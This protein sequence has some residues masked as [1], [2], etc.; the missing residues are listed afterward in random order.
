[1]QWIAELIINKSK[2][3]DYDVF[4]LVS[5]I[6]VIY[7]LFKIQLILSLT[8]DLTSCI[9]LKWQLTTKSYLD[10]Y[11]TFLSIAVLF[12]AWFLLHCKK[13]LSN[14]V[15]HNWIF[16]LVGFI[17]F[18]YWFRAFYGMWWYFELERQS[19]TQDQF[20]ELTGGYP[21]R[22]PFNSSYIEKNS[23]SICNITSN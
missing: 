15:Q 9:H 23:S 18:F 2:E 22:F 4:Y 12:F 19:I 10:P 1:M 8:N 11:F 13:L 7:F 20:I 16:I 5:S 21:D 6:V 14:S 3:L 17:F